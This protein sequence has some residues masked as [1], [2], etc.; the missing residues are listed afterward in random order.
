MDINKIIEYL[1]DV[2]KEVLIFCF[3]TLIGLLSWLVKSLIEGPLTS[4]KETF[5]RFMDKRLEILISI[6]TRLLFIAYVNEEDSSKEIKE[7]LQTILRDGKIAYLSQETYA[8]VVRIAID[9][10][11]NND[12]VHST[13]RDIDKDVNKQITKV[14]DE[15]DFYIKF[16]HFSPLKRVWSLF[17][18][19][20]LYILSITLCLFFTFLIF[21][22]IIFGTNWAR[23]LII[24]L[25][26]IGVLTLNRLFTNKP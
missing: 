3:T 12:L 25:T 19:G 26:I 10:T 5:N 8:N 6:K 9:I 15:I 13:I 20:T 1:K 4:S 23:I 2:N 24:L 11:T 14:K 18:M 16:S 21:Y 7:E 17:L 22:G